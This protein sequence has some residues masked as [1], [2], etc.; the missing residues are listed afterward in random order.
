MKKM[1][2]LTAALMLMVASLGVAWAIP[3]G[4]GDVS[5]ATACQNGIGNN[6]FLSDPLAV[7]AQSFFGFTDWAYLQ[8]QNTPGSLETNINY[9]L[10]VSPLTG[11]QTGTWSFN[12]AL[13]D[14]Y[15]D[16]MILLK[17]G[18]NKVNGVDYFFSG[19]LLD[20]VLMPTSGT[21][22]TGDKDLSHLTLY[23][24]LL[25]PDNPPPPVP[26][27][28]TLLLLGSGLAGVAWYVRKRKQG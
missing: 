2:T 10:T 20:K 7:N 4:A 17:S 23:A 11:T 22:D 8:K 5:G 1:V 12:P 16:V 6:D 18:K 13:W 24:R 14:G 25:K 28:G 3:C 26:E 9:G 21:W 27:P 15:T 19:Y